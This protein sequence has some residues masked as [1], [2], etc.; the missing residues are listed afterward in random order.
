[1][2]GETIQIYNNG[3]MMHDLILN[4]VLRLMKN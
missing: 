3:N 4:Q 1:M 2:A